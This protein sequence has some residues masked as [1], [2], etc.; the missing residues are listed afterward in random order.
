[1]F[2]LSEEELYREIQ[3][4]QYILDESKIMYKTIEFGITTNANTL[5]IYIGQQRLI[6]EV[7]KSGKSKDEKIKKLEALKKKFKSVKTWRMNNG[8]IIPIVDK[9]IK[10]V[11]LQKGIDRCDK[12]ISILKGKK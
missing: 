4:S 5:P 9:K 6:K 8:N 12:E 1:M 11:A 10:E 3:E 7:L 2:L